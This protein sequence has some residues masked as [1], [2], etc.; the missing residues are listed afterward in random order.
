MNRLFAIT[1]IINYAIVVFLNAFTDLGHKII[2]QNT[3]FKVYD[4]YLQIILTAIVN[5]LILL[6]FILMFSPSGFLA[7][8]FPKNKIMEYSAAFAVVITLG[9]TYSY[10]QGWFFTAFV[11]TFLLALQSALYG[12]AK[13]GYIKELVGVQHITAGNALIQGTTTVA[14]LGGI[15]FYTVLFEGMFSEALTTKEEILKAIAPLGWLLVVGS[16]IEWFLAS[17]LP[18]K[19]IEASQRRFEFQKY[20]QGVY[21]RRNFKIITRKREI[22][23]AII[24]LSLFWSISQVVLAIFG[25]YA[26]SELGVTNTIFVQGVM[27]LAGVGIVL[28]S[29]LASHFSKYYINTGLVAIGSVM[30]TL[31]VFLI[32]FVSSMALL[33]FM[34]ML[35]G[36]AAGLLM[37]PL[38]AHIQ[39][40]AP[41][42]HLGTILAGSN[43]VQNIFMF[44]FLL[45][46]TLFAYFGMNSTFLFYLMGFVGICLSYI[47]LKRYKAMTFW[48]IFEMFSKMRHRYNYVGLENIPSSKGVLLLGNHVSWVDWIIVQ[49]PLQ[50]RINYMMDKDIYYWPLLHS[51]FKLGETIPVSTKASKDAFV[52]AHKRLL[53][54]KIV[55]LYPE[56][57]ISKDGELGKFYRGYEMIPQNYDGVIVPFFIEG[58][59]GSMFA[60]YKP[61][62]R[63]NIFRRRKINVYFAPPVPMDTKADEIR[64]IILA[65]K[66]KYETK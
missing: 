42:V 2:I 34:F 44:S 58:I 15:I 56:G 33:A 35:F 64:D 55:G 13:Y 52:E 54:G 39:F 40:L 26:K 36:I 43:F 12:P 41:T 45:L 10:Y 11:M 57:E 32:P 6:P 14:I 49:L 4:G 9:I 16:V 22:F 30:I 47:V 65:M 29:I 5:A 53:G 21:L 31:L 48:A 23:E 46:T 3:V 61:K 18:N 50:K 28:G 62:K 24:A 7:D 19:M 38:N 20:I 8:K 60:K 27:A 37:V 17:K 51:A 1:G 66:E 25:E 59:Y 63:R